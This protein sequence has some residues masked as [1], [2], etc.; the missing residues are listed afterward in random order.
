MLVEMWDEP[1]FSWTSERFDVRP[2]DVLPKPVQK[3]HPP[4]WLAG[5]SAS[6]ARAAGRGGLAFLDLSGAEPD[7]LEIHRDAYTESRAECDPN[8]LVSVAAVGVAA[9]LEASE[10]G[11]ER[12]ASLES[13]GIDEAIL[14]VGPLEGGHEEALE[15]IRFLASGTEAPVH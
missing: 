14:R 2:I 6:H 11:G 12:L 13:L 1:T 15:R 7:Q 9:E 4:I 8:D 10:A 5:W 3:P